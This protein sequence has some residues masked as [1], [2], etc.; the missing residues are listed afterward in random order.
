M[1]WCQKR[2]RR[3]VNPVERRRS[4]AAIRI[5]IRFERRI[6]TRVYRP[7]Y[8]RQRLVLGNNTEKSYINT[9]RRTK[10]IES[11]DTLAASNSASI[12]SPGIAASPAIAVD[13]V[14]MLRERLAHR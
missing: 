6:I 14:R 1:C 2:V 13:V 5:V 3:V 10:L 12:D 11:S 9:L 7:P 4:V 8:S